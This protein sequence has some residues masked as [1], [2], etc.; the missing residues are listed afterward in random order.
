[1]LYLGFGGEGEPRVAMNM[2]YLAWDKQQINK[3]FCKDKPP[4][5]ALIY[6]NT[7]GNDQF[8]TLSI[9]KKR[10][11]TKGWKRKKKEKKRGKKDK[12]WVVETC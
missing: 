5:C 8:H 6:L 4:L 9:Q 2:P 3:A 11:H 7:K 1:M 12:E 10:K